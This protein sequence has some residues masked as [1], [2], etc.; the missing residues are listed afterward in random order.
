MKPS[1]YKG[2]DPLD[3][4]HTWEDR[5]RELVE[6]RIREVPARTFFSEEEADLL[7]AIVERLIPQPDRT[8]A[9]KI[10]ITPWIDQMLAADD[11]DGFRKGG[12]PWDQE[13]W[14]QVLVGVEQT[15]RARHERGFLDLDAAEQ[16]DVLSAVQ[17]GQAEGEVW[18]QLKS[19][20]AFEK[21]IQE[22]VSVYYAHPSAWSEI[23]WPGP[24]S[25]RGYMR[26][27][28]GQIDPWQP[29]ASAAV[30]SV[31]LV[32]DAEEGGGHPSGSGGATH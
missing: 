11:T 6:S 24:A 12:M 8:E 9:E 2:F 16:D 20:A 27:G 7:D 4:A 17:S 21:V 23:G 18:Q 1:P 31:P 26:T 3:A 13:V 25:K 28:Y 32:E 22:L 19:D 30:T 29:R 15:S 5:T 14:R 10:P